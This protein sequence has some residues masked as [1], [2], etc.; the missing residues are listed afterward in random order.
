MGHSLL[1]ALYER[2][3]GASCF[4]AVTT[5]ASNGNANTTRPRTD[6]SAA[7]CPPTSCNVSL[8]A[9]AA[10]PPSWAAVIWAARCLRSGPGVR[11]MC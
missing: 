3:T 8:M 11:P 5:S 9:S 7:V 2:C 1:A 10:E 6:P 4:N